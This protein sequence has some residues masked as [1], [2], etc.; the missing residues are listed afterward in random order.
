MVLVEHTSHI[1]LVFWSDDDFA[2]GI[3]HEVKEAI[4]TV[5]VMSA[6]REETELSVEKDDCV[7]LLEKVFC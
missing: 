6:V 3:I 4:C 1:L 7:V 5:T 2:V